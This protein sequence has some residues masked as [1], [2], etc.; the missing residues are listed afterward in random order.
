MQSAF[1]GKHSSMSGEKHTQGYEIKKKRE[2]L[3]YKR[4]SVFQ[5]QSSLPV[6]FVAQ[7]G[8]K[9]TTTATATSMQQI[10]DMIG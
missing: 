1:D 2:T 5:E 8:V 9:E 3:L 7:K 10:D 6:P 4:D